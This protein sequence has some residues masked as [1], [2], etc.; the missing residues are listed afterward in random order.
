MPANPYLASALLRSTRTRM[1][2]SHESIWTSYNRHGLCNHSDYEKFFPDLRILLVY[3]I[4]ASEFVPSTDNCDTG[5]QPTSKGLAPVL[6]RHRTA[7]I[8]LTLIFKQV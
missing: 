6:K 8:E 1:K 2:A 7:Y 5:Q 4:F 3:R